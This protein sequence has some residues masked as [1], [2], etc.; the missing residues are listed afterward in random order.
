MQIYLIRHGETDWNA[1]KRMQ[2]HNKHIPLNALGLE[3]A[4]T[5]ATLLQSI[6]F[7]L[8]ITSPLDRARHTAEIINAD[9]NIEIIPDARLIERCLGVAE[10]KTLEEIAL[11]VLGYPL[12][13]DKAARNWLYSTHLPEGA[14]TIEAL[15]ERAASTFYDLV[16][17]HQDKTV[18]IVSH[19]AW[20]RALA[21][22]IA[23][24]DM[25]FG[26]AATYIAQSVDAGWR[27]SPA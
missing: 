18:L 26:N 5:A 11:E 21:Q 7:D 24:I 1:Q 3:Q 10:G 13:D 12:P 20:L 27:I 17:T 22:R 19:G 16:N 6:P 8:I 23:N 4:R 14:E 2:G 9:R 15:R 25:F